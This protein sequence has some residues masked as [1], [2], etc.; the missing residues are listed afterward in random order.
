M[1]RLGNIGCKYTQWTDG[2]EIHFLFP[3]NLSEVTSKDNSVLVSAVLWSEP[4]SE[5]FGFSELMVVF[6]TEYKR[7]ITIE[8][9]LREGLHDIAWKKWRNWLTQSVENCLIMRVNL[10]LYHDVSMVVILMIGRTVTPT[11]TTIPSYMVCGITL[12]RSIQYISVNPL[13]VLAGVYTHISRQTTGQE[14][15]STLV[16]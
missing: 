4:I 2:A 16:F 1:Q 5:G 12:M 10:A 9:M 13:P 8:Q 15:S 14:K 7:N 11:A 6:F 3:E